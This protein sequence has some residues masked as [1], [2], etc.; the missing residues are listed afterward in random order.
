MRCVRLVR[1]DVLEE[2]VTSILGVERVRERRG[3]LAV[4]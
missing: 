4:G 1:T 3:V 2:H